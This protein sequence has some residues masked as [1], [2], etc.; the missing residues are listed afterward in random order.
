MAECVAQLVN[1]VAARASKVNWL[2]RF[3]EWMA[4]MLL[5]G[6]DYTK[7]KIIHTHFVGGGG[8]KS[9]LNIH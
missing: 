4:V 3:I 2:S 1:T 6:S 5:R 7:S 9:Q 8:S